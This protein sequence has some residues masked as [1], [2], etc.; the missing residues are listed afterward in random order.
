MR[1]SIE[2][3]PQELADGIADVLARGGHERREP[4][5][6]AVVGVNPRVGDN[7]VELRQEDWNAAVEAARTSFFALQRAARIMVERGLAGRIVVV[8]PVHA[9]R[10]SRGCGLAAVTGSFLATAAQ[11]A[12][13][14]LGAKG[15]RVN[16]LAFGPPEGSTPA[17]V[18]AAVPLARLMRAQDLGMV[19]RLLASPEADYLTGAVI[20]V[21]GGYQVTKSVGGSPFSAEQ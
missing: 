9:L 13:I 10:T 11:V 17:R 5:E 19:C 4:A 7:L 18:A 14:E 12:A 6:L 21:D 3:L 20:A 2:G 1:V 8:V 16:V 15:I